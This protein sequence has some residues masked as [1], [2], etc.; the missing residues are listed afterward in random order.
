MD[1]VFGRWL[2]GDDNAEAESQPTTG[3]RAGFGGDDEPVLVAMIDGPVQIEMAKDALETAG[4]PAHVKQNS[5]GPIYG[6]SV[7]SFGT[8]EVWVVRPLAE[9]A[10]ET[11][12]GIGVLRDPGN[13]GMDQAEEQI[14]EQS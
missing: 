4:I 6:L 12:V 7:G 9:Q 1:M 10:R 5:L 11:L 14:D 8:A 13:E 3:T 2:R